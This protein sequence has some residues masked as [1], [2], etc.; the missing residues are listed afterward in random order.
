MNPEAWLVS[1]RTGGL[2]EPGRDRWQPLRVG[3]VNL[4]EYDEA[5]FWYADGR[6]VLRGGNGAGKTKLLE[7]T[8]LMLLRGEI[9]PSVLD[10][11]GSQHR[12]MKFNLLP[13]GEEDDPRPATDSGLGYAWAEY[14]RLDTDGTARYLVC[15]MG[16][17]ARRGSGTEKVRRWM[18]L[19][20][21]RPGPELVLAPPAGPLEEKDLRKEPGVRVFENGDTY[22]AA[23]GGELFGLDKAGY[24]NLTELLKQLRRPKLGER[25]NPRELESTLRD[26][27]PR[28][29]TG[30]V[31]QL[32]EGWD[33]LEELRTGVQ[34]LQNA[35]A[36]VARFTRRYWLPWARVVVRRRSDDVAAATTKLDRTTRRRKEAEEK[37][38]VVQR[39]VEEQKVELARTKRTRDDKWAELRQ[40]FDSSAY[41]D[42][43]AAS[44]NAKALA[45]RAEAAER[46]ARDARRAADRQA[47]R[48]AGV[49][50]VLAE[51]R[52]K[53]EEAEREVGRRG[54]SVLEAARAAGA[55]VVRLVEARDVDGLHAAHGARADRFANAARLHREWKAADRRLEESGRTLK[56]RRD[57]V[58]R[59]EGQV[60]R[61]DDDVDRAVEA[62]T[63]A[64]GSWA[65]ALT[66]APC[67]PEQLVSWHALVPAVAEGRSP[68]LSA[69]LNEHAKRTERRSL[70]HRTR[71]ETERESLEKQSDE[72]RARIEGM[73]ATVDR[74]PDAP[75]SWARRERPATGGAPLWA[76]VQPRDGAG[77]D[78]APLARL[79]AAL[80]A[81]GML[82]AW[83]TPD[84]RLITEAETVLTAGPAVRPNLLTVLEPTPAG[85]MTH[86]RIAAVLAGIGWSTSGEDA[87]ADVWLAMDGRWRVGAL[88]G[89]AVPAQ[90]A[91]YLG[92][93]ARSAARLRTIRRLEGELALLS[94][95]LDEKRSAIDATDAVLRRL[96]E[97]SWD[98]EPEHHLIGAV[99]RVEAI[100]PH[101]VQARAD[102]EAVERRHGELTAE[103]DR[104]R[105]AAAGYAAEHDFPLDRL[106]SVGAALSGL[107]GAVRD[108][109][110][111]LK[112]FHERLNRLTEAETDAAA[113]RDDAVQ[114]RADAEEAGD[115][116]RAAEIAATTAQE[117]LTVSHQEQLDRRAELEKLV[118]SLDKGISRLD[119]ELTD[120][121]LMENDACRVLG[122]HTRARSEAEEHR[123]LAVA[124][125]WRAA[126]TGLVAP[127][128]VSVP[129]TRNVDSTLA[130]ARIVRREIDPGAADAAAQERAWRRCHAQLQQSRLDLLP[131]RDAKVHDE[132]ELPRCVVL[133]DPAEGWVAPDIAEASLG[134]QV[135]EMESKFKDEQQR[136]LTKLLG[137]AFIEHLKDRLD[138][139]E[140]VFTRI[141]ECLVQHP[142]RQ[143]HTLQ[144]V[145]RAHPE[146]P[147]AGQV[148]EAL[149]QGYEL[150]TSA[151]QDMVRDFLRRKV[152][153]ARAEAAD[154][155]LAEWQDHLALALDYRRWL[156]IQVEFKAGPGGRWRPFDAARHG[157]KSGGEKVVLLSQPLFAAAVVAYDAAGAAAPRQIW[158]DEA[159]TGVDDEVKARFMGLTVELDLDVM[160]TAHDEWCR[161]ATVP[162]AAVYDLARHKHLPGV[163]ALPHLW[164][165]G[166]WTVL[167]RTEPA[168]HTVSAG[169]DDEGAMF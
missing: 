129:D 77:L 151:Q 149:Q 156:R 107:L 167:D 1:A 12:T 136:A 115:A 113:A 147:E 166:E 152:E 135:A 32:V 83:L 126:D 30:E 52:R 114:A 131:K 51:A 49:D 69:A 7:L 66:A 39:K 120:L 146:D 43:V 13:T 42:A 26:A 44:V 99:H 139:T 63:A 15:G 160:I 142:T 38:E 31:E 97:E 46:A 100:R 111:E 29:A 124:A 118:E 23:L 4:W 37:L 71:L 55:D 132:D 79:E 109:A 159:M 127:L 78:G 21:R 36:E 98:A 19:T 169:S 117:Q 106:E 2:P 122:D 9:H 101:L 84:G 40:L 133:A 105:A 116:A 150:L 81:S 16:A 74:P 17:A 119:G 14:G 5:D 56:S 102:L 27:L 145:W 96:A 65:A 104:A 85:D 93:T 94:G 87:S 91:S 163:D 125:W 76:C 140:S 35:A 144:L 45:D 67:T 164:C 54:D 68:K 50:D 18:F 138:Y 8:T 88:T 10:P 41:K 80:A 158:L 24:D 92:A 103:S 130:A 59:L 155:G 141:N 162:A 70:E 123:T 73:R 57:G 61:G 34:R 33:R 60:E 112:I 28:L 86:D 143:G 154:K 75:V 48:L 47:K 89:F 134:R 64:L 148:V 25:L 108:Y 3:V 161:Y 157:A 168:R 128:G 11:F 110:A 153:A 22:R 62:L 90:P 20:G 82:D 72:I 6:L 95:T 121:R 165:G 58:V 53:H 137:S